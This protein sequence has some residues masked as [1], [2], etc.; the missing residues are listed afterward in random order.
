[1]VVFSPL[2]D[3]ALEQ[4]LDKLL[5]QVRDRLR[6]RL[7]DLTVTP[8]ARRLLLR[9]GSDPRAGARALEQA[10]DRLLVQPLGRALIAG[11]L[12]AGA[13]VRADAAGG[14]LVLPRQGSPAPSEGER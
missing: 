13:A 5:A 1:M 10:V 11:D 14:R 12:A 8:A 4:V 9:H 6:D 7:I 3:A 2:D